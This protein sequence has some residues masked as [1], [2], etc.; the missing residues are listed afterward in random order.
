MVTARAAVAT[1]KAATPA[2]KPARNF[3]EV[4]IGPSYGLHA[5]ES[6]GDGGIPSYR[7]VL[8]VTNSRS[9]YDTD[10]GFHEVPLP[11]STGTLER[12]IGARVDF[13]KSVWANGQ[14]EDRF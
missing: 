3:E 6:G 2:I 12:E 1:P 13:P 8:P 4:F 9:F 7:H 14:R 11:P 5:R 10:T